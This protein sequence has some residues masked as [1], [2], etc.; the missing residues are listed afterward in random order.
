MHEYDYAAKS[1]SKIRNEKLIFNI[2]REVRRANDETE[3][4]ELE[5]SWA[6]EV[7]RISRN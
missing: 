6:N 4:A 3:M 2:R 5:K 7:Y 1:S